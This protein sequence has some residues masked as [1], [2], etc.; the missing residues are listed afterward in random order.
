MVVVTGASSGMG[1]KIALDFAK[2]GA[3]VVVVVARC[4]ERL[5]EIVAEA[6][7]NVKISYKIR[8]R[9]AT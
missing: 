2:E 1:R 4:K 9:L 3:T 7:I 6:V 8:W 5:E